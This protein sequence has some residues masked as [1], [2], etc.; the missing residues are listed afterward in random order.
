MTQTLTTER[1]REIAER[2]SPSL[3]WGEAEQISA[4]LLANREAQPV[5]N[6]QFK[7]VADLFAL[8]WENGEVCSYI[9]D[10][11]K[12]VL[13][14]TGYTGTCVH[15]YV[16]L[17]RLQEAY[18]APRAPA[19]TSDLLEAMTEVIRISDRDH[20]AWSR[21]KEAIATCR[22]AM[23]A[24]PVSQGYKLNSPEIPDSWIACTEQ[25]PDADGTYWCWFG[26]EEPSV[27]Q[28][29][30]CIWISRHNEWCDSA[31][32]HWMP[33]PAAPTQGGKQ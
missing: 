22:A 17:E 15:E 3:R 9:T 25:T 12:T 27:I 30:V 10:P 4:E 13:W 8:G 31:V 21:A 5:A 28:Q 1:L 20:E 16:K 14:L 7:P 33:L 2:R 26:K 11:E 23:L 29:R 6:T 19:V 24:Q 18:T 32:T